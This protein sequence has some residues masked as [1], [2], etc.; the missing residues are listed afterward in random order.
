MAKNRVIGRF[1]VAVVITAWIVIAL[2]QWAKA[3]AMANLQ[4]GELV[5][6]I[7]QLVQLRLAFNDSAAFSLG[8][9]ITWIFTII[10]SLAALAILWF[11][12]KIETLSWAI[13]AGVL[14]GG[15]VGNLIDR[16]TRAT[17]FA[18]G[19][20][21]DFIQ[22]PFNFA[23]FNIADMAIVITCT[24]GALR[25]IRGEQIGKAK[26]EEAQVEPKSASLTGN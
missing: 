11:S 8:F 3:V 2:D 18:D 1:A 24:L 22:L 25:L 7:G 19:T 4:P 13:M 23:I 6:F 5:P 26:L 12:R 20:V 14:L 16:I 15:V 10:S 21:I 17:G 9:G